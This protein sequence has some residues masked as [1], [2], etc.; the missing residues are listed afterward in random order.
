MA[1][2]RITGIV[3]NGQEEVA[4]NVRLRFTPVSITGV[5]ISSASVRAKTNASGVLEN[6]DGDDY[7]DLIQ[8][9]TYELRGDILGYEDGEN[10]QVPVGASATFASL[11]SIATFPSEGLTVQSNGT[12]LASLIGTFNIVGATVEQTSAG[13]ARLTFTGGGGGALSD[14]SDVSLTSL[15]TNDFLKY[16][17]SD[18]VNRTIAQVK[19]DL[20]LNLVEN[21]AASGLYQ[22]LAN[23]ATDFSTVNNTLYPTVAAV[24][25]YA[26]TA[27]ANLVDSSPSTLDTLNELAAALGNDPNFATTITTSIGTKL[28]KA[29]NLSDLTDA[30]TAR[31]NLGLAIGSNVQAYSADLA[32]IAALTLANDDILQRKAGAWTNRTLA[33]L[34]SDLSLN[35]VENTALST[36]AGSANLTTLGTIATGTWNATAIA[37]AKVDKTGSS[38]AD[39]AT[40]SAA[41]LN[42]GTL[43]L[44]RL[45]G[46]TNTEIAAGA[47]IAYSKLN[48]TGAIL[49]ADLAGSIALS[50]LSITGTPDGTKFLRDDGVWAAA[51]GGGGL[52]VGTTTITSGANTK[53]LFNNSGVL[54]EY[55]ITGTGNVVMSASPTLTGT[56]AA[57]AATLS[58]TLVQTSNSATAFES[59]PNGSTNPVLRLV[60]STSSQSDGISITGNTSNTTITTISPN[61]NSNLNIT[62]KGTG[63][64]QLTR[65]GTAAAPSI[66]IGPI[67]SGFFNPGGNTVGVSING[68]ETWRW[69]DSDTMLVMSNNGKISY[70]SSLDMTVARAAAAS[71]RIYGT[72][73]VTNAITNSLILGHNSSGTPAAGFGSGLKFQLES[74]TTEDQDA[75]QIAAEW[76][77]STHASRT[78]NLVFKTVNNAAALAEAFRLK[79]DL[80]A[81]FAGIPRFNG[82]NSTGAGSA[83]L[84]SNSPASTLSAPYTWI[85]VVTSD[86]SSGFV[87]VWK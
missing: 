53:V 15:A 54:G 62:T 42:S 1:T 50:K 26:D 31:T 30:A 84:G 27:I 77:V 87:P 86:G 33:Q 44:A 59:G 5:P 61:S 37:W 75:G 41:D 40:R 78:S 85:S 66:L 14:L 45:S 46:I 11:L 35:L 81:V 12:P 74:S 38:L 2:C 7:L 13:V 21:A 10:I 9:G 18:W 71:G 25:T 79:G 23:K 63:W 34:K 72:D 67:L 70:G 49:N 58:S 76:E 17:G 69:H 19:S 48:L 51:G 57:A 28:A 80:S 24:K 4:A 32:A 6:D 3:Y 43:P 20:S 83:L 8:G 22:T 16:N 65:G 73:A 29:S 47:A 68:T 55:T 39:L 36:W 82:T 60:N 64:V 56:L 52:T